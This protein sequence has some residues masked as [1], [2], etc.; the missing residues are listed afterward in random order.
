M[1]FFLFA[2][3]YIFVDQLWSYSVQL[4]QRSLD[5]LSKFEYTVTL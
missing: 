2:R 1:F 4:I 3:L 5:H